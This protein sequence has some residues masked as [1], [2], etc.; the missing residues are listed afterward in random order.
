M[1]LKMKNK[2][3]NTIKWLFIEK[4]ILR[5]EMINMVDVY[6]TLIILGRKTFEQVP[7]KLKSKVKE[8]LNSMGL[9]ENGNPLE[10]VPQQ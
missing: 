7:N 4:F 9:D 6:C 5:E 10:T 3:I 1:I 2:I 8:Q